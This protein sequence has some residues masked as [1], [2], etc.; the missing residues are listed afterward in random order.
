MKKSVNRQHSMKAMRFEKNGPKQGKRKSCRGISLSFLRLCAFFLTCV[1]IPALMVMPAE[2]R[3]KPGYGNQG[4]SQ[5]GQSGLP[6]KDKPGALNGETILENLLTSHSDASDSDTKESTVAEIDTFPEN[7]CITW[8]V[9]GIEGRVKSAEV[10]IGAEQA[11]VSEAGRLIDGEGLAPKT[12]I[13]VDN[14]E[15]IG[16]RPNQE[17][18]KAIL[19]R[20]IWNH[21][22]DERFA[23][24]TF[25]DK[26]VT[27]SPLAYAYYLRGRAYYERNLDNQALNDF[28]AAESTPHNDKIYPVWR[29][30][31]YQGLIYSDREQWEMAY[32]KLARAWDASGHQDRDIEAAMLR[33]KRHAYPPAA[34]EPRKKQTPQRNSREFD[35]E[36][37]VSDVLISILK[38]QAAKQSIYS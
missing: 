16:T 26:S 13:L 36:K 14:S 17:K 21:Q 29:T 18:I 4:S 9:R 5:S 24:K 8:F 20:L 28:S 1:M 31:Y 12:L 3:T 19:T 10:Y 15:S 33:A 34:E 37:V 6:G 30:Y 27:D 38:D 2:A 35:W 11:E 32:G 22:Y 25:A 7:P 23:I